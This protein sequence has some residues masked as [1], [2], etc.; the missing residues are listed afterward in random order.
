PKITQRMLTLQ[1]RELE[2]DGVIHREVYKQVT[3]KVEYSLTEFGRTLEPVIL[4]MKDLGEK[5]RDRINKIETTRKAEEV[6]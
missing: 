5:Y 1:L 3:P 4:H 6:I 2:R